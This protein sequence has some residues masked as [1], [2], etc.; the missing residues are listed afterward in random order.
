MCKAGAVFA[1]DCNPSVV[2]LSGLDEGDCIVVECHLRCYCKNY[3]DAQEEYRADKYAMAVS[4]YGP[5]FYLVTSSSP[6]NTA[7]EA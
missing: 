1:S 7:K 4:N 2:R 3:R 5:G 6:F